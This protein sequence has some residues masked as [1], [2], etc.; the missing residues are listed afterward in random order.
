M[1]SF[2]TTYDALVADLQEHTEDDSPEYVAD[3]PDI[4]NRAEDATVRAL[5]LDI[6]NA[7]STT[8]VTSA[9]TALAV[10]TGALDIEWLQFTASGNFAEPRKLAYCKAYGGSGE[11]QFYAQDGEATL[12]LAPTPDSAYAVDIRY[13][14]RPPKLTSS[15][16]TNWLTDNVAD[17][18]LEAALVESERFLIDPT[19]VAVH[20][21]TFTTKAAM[22][23]QEFSGLRRSEF[24]LAQT[25]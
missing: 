10:P 20:Q 9:S 5:N 12:Y 1:A 18:L 11:P 16:Q 21:E 2:A 6:F 24:A 23:A 22:A 25:S 7:T 17:L 14:A 13:L 3:L 8:A 15:N 19:Q 4:V